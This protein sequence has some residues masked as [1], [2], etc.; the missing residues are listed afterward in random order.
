MKTRFVEPAALFSGSKNRPVFDAV[1]E[2]L[3]ND[4]RGT[5]AATAA[6]MTLV[7]AER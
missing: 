2:T 4:D 5:A 6:V 3:V 7:A 1:S